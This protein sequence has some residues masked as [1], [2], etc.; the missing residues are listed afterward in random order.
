MPVNNTKKP[1]AKTSAGKNTSARRSVPTAKKPSHKP[2]QRQAPQRTASAKKGEPIVLARA[3][4]NESWKP[5]AKA[6][7]K[8][9]TSVRSRQAGN[10]QKVNSK[11]KSKNKKKD[12]MTDTK[13]IKITVG[14]I[15]GAIFLIAVLVFLFNAFELKLW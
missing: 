2:A 7:P 4:K 13:L 10:N 9:A 6:Q 11:P 8:P 15:F 14:C 12:S 3:S 1:A 5:L